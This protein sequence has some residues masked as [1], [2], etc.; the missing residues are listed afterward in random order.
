V[1]TDY[2][3]YVVSFGSWY[4]KYLEGSSA[5]NE[6][7]ENVERLQT[8]FKE[9]KSK[10]YVL[11]VSGVVEDKLSVER[12]MLSNEKIL[13]FNS[14]LE[15][16]LESQD[17]YSTSRITY[18]DAWSKMTTYGVD[19]KTLDGL[20]FDDSVYDSL[21]EL[22]L[23]NRC[24]ED[25]LSTKLPLRSSCCASY[26]SVDGK[27]ILLFSVLL[28]LGSFAFISGITF[29]YNIL[30]DAKTSNTWTNRKFA[31]AI[32]WILLT[33]VL[34]FLS[35]RTNM[36]LKQRKEFS[37]FNFSFLLILFTVVSW[38]TQTKKEQPGFLN[39]DITDEWKGWMQVIILVYHYTGASAISPV[40]NAARILVASYLFM[41]GYGHASYFLKK[42]DFSLSRAGSVLLR[43][44][45]LSIVLAYFM[46]SSF[47]A[48]YFSPL[49]SFWFIVIYLVM[50][51]QNNFN[52]NLLFLL[53]K[54]IVASVTVAAALESG[55]MDGLFNIIVQLSG[56][57]WDL[58]EW[59]FRVSLDRFIVFVG[60]IC[61][62][63]NI[64][65]FSNDLWNH[66][67][68]YLSSLIL[69]ITGIV[70]TVVVCTMLSKYDYN[71]I[72][73]WFSC[74]PVLS[75]IFLR[76]LTPAFTQVYSTFCSYIGKISLETFI[77]QF[78][79]WLA[80]DTA[81]LL[82][83]F[84][85]AYW[86]NFLATSIIFIIICEKSSEAT[87]VVCDTISKSKFTTKWSIC[88]FIVSLMLINRI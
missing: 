7:A 78:H 54:I 23:N 72:H 74:I 84:P 29:S 24:N 28:F 68:Y 57:R 43:L 31:Q 62:I 18:V 9:S 60:M 5:L 25:I 27:Q 48:Y 15:D 77:L 65:L 69:S 47:Q 85:Q 75:F 39:R 55:I 38:L 51:I 13:Q 32:L 86:L 19:D 70:S 34:C 50:Y 11:P 56:A 6:Y 12:R 3:I 36:L 41:T 79:I 26:P 45:F 63:L 2:Y 64:K 17:R 37:E 22:I 59:H 88:I 58:K 67:A 81:G 10:A 80:L 42:K 71:K 87:S 30:D 52:D 73:A 82:V 1:K 76:N 35:D 61:G 33:C 4:I 20:H 53:G 44:N 40:Y 49:V 46:N 8:L 21:L 14:Q 83:L 16:I 66:K